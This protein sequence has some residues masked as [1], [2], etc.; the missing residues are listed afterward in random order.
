MRLGKIP[1]HSPLQALKNDAVCTWIPHSSQVGDADTLY[2]PCVISTKYFVQFML[3]FTH[4]HS[5]QEPFNQISKF[6]L[7]F[8]LTS[9]HT[10]SVS[11]WHNTWLPDVHVQFVVGSAN[12]TSPGFLVFRWLSTQ[13]KVGRIGGGTSSIMHAIWAGPEQEHVEKPSFHVSP[14][15]RMFPL[16]SVQCE[17]KVENE[18]KHK[19][20]QCTAHWSL[21]SLSWNLERFRKWAMNVTIRFMILTFHKKQL[22]NL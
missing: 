20:S 19:G 11:S 8:P 1:F 7:N 13:I 15:W 21:V 4:A 5:T 16:M 6:S 2:N 9:R 12:Q 14:I 3:P 18:N 10:G 22:W 17:A